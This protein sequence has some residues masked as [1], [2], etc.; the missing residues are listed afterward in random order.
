MNEKIKKNNHIRFYSQYLINNERSQ[1][2]HLTK[3]KLSKNN[4]NIKNNIIILTNKSQNLQR[5][6]IKEITESKFKLNYEEKKNKDNNNILINDYTKEEKLMNNSVNINNINLINSMNNITFYDNAINNNKNKI[7]KKSNNITVNKKNN[8]TKEKI[9]IN[10]AKIQPNKNFGINFAIKGLKE[11]TIYFINK[12]IKEK[13][14]EKVKTKN[15]D[16]IINVNKLS[17]KKASLNNLELKPNSTSNIFYLLEKKMKNKNNWS[18]PKNTTS[19]FNINKQKSEE[20]F[21]KNSKIKK[22]KSNKIDEINI[23]NCN[24]EINS[25]MFLRGN[26]T[27]TNKNINK[28]Y[29]FRFKS[30][31]KLNNKYNQREKINQNE[32][33]FIPKSNNN[34]ILNIKKM[35]QSSPKIYRNELNNNSFEKIEVHKNYFIN[36]YLISKNIEKN[37]KIPYIEKRND[38]FNLLMKNTHQKS[39][40]NST[41]KI[42]KNEN[43]EKEKENLVT[44]K[45]NKIIYNKKQLSLHNKRQSYENNLNNNILSP[46]YV[47]KKILFDRL[48]K[49]N[50]NNNKNIFLSDNLEE[51]SH[52]KDN[53]EKSVINNFTYKKKIPLNNIY[54]KP[55]LSFINNSFLFLGKDALLKKNKINKIMEENKKIK[56]NMKL[57]K[58]LKQ[59]ENKENNDLSIIINSDNNNSKEITMDTN[60]NLNEISIINKINNKVIY[61]SYNFIRK[62]LSYFIKINNYII[63]QP[64]FIS[65]K[66]ININNITKKLPKK[67]IYYITK[68]R[69]RIIYIIPKI[70]VCYWRK[71]TTIDINNLNIIIKPAFAERLSLKG[72]ESYNSKIIQTTKKRVYIEKYD[73]KE[74]DLKKT[75]KGLQLL[76]KIADKRISLSSLLI[77]KTK[78]IFENNYYN[79]NIKNDLIENLNIITINNYEVIL[80]KISDLIIFNNNK[81]INISQIIKNQNEFIE[82]IINKGTKERIYIS[83]YTK[84]CKDLFISIMTRIDNKNDDIDIFDKLTKEKSIKNILKIKIIKRIENINNEIQGIIYFICEL[85]ENKIFSIKTGFDI[86]DLLFKKYSNDLNDIYLIGI[87]ILLKRIKHIIYEKNKFEHIQRYNK[88]IKNNL[89][90]IFQKRK[91]SDNLPKF[92]YYKLYNVLQNNNNILIRQE[93][94]NNKNMEM[95]K[96]DLEKIIIKNNKSDINLFISEISI[97]Y[98]T[99]INT[100]KSMELWELFY[101]YI[102][103]CI[104]IIN[105]ENKIK[106]ANKYINI[107]INNLA[108][109]I[110][111]E[112]WEILHYKL[113]TL[114]LSINDIC[115]DNK[116]MYQIMG[117]LL[118]ALISKK[119]FYI[120]DLNNFLEKDNYIIISIT[121]V[122]KYTIIFSEKEA[123]KFHNDFKQTKLFF[124]NN[125]FYDLVTVPL[126]KHFYE[127]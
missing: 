52:T 88:Y 113:I 84:L 21:K 46:Y 17:L 87:E 10:K 57:N 35:N 44:E 32:I 27:T 60:I 5:K 59:N 55:D 96:S 76:E 101:Y 68:K 77:K 38:S 25:N 74:N 58:F 48:N 51:F 117:F 67:S 23:S 124:G 49:S 12:T 127:I 20:K 86:L 108:K 33:T 53:L 79:R 85:L 107:I 82:I 19:N 24:D 65:K 92:L 91:K 100:K 112:A 98:N 30:E 7:Q 105:S 111:D 97:K 15:K 122:V 28:D 11:N 75:E 121:K 99:E 54:R 2:N 106:L 31:N 29:F 120:K 95:I 8:Y 13:G 26:I 36:D 3:I 1:D 72:K 109:L 114:F 80:N 47:T 73:K 102:E 18:T 63:K 78:R 90:N 43:F 118:Y 14:K 110:K 94:N 62:Y 123:K 93:F 115:V 16:N 40:T 64:C 4:P 81:K 69:K 56:Y 126:K 45:D 50:D 9:N 66:R 103:A 83:I 125:D 70:D 116:Y 42:N 37:K 22:E 6:N 34:D 89:Y 119:L 61:N 104:D 71:D 41:E 39:W